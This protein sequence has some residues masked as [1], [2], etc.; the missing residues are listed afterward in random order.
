MHREKKCP[1]KKWPSFNVPQKS[2]L[3][4]L[5]PNNSKSA[6]TLLHVHVSTILKG[7]K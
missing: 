3:R 5:T 7:E 4:W 1:D 6:P 2:A